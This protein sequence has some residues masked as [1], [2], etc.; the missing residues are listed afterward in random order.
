[1][2]HAIVDCLTAGRADH[3]DKTRQQ[4]A[5]VMVRFEE[6]LSKHIDRKPN[7]PALCA[8]MGVAERT[9]RMCCAEVLGVSP[10]RYLRLQRL[11]RARAAL[12]RANP[13]TASVAEV[14]RD[15]QFLEFGRFAVTYRS[16]FGE[17]PST[18][19]QRDSRA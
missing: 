17:S 16:I 1:M 12:R 4:H 2:V 6:A 10:T 3:V 7:M 18:T 5:A 19:L 15:N 9:L 13:S 11:N 14:A 8:E